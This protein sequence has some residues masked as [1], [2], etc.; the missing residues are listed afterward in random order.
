MIF[1]T[2]SRIGFCDTRKWCGYMINRILL[3]KFKGIKNWGEIIENA[4]G[5]EHI[6]EQPNEFWMDKKNVGEKKYDKSFIKQIKED[7]ERL[8][9]CCM[10]HSIGVVCYLDELYPRLLRDIPS[11]PKMIYYK[12]RLQKEEN[13]IAVVGS[14]NSSGY[15]NRIAKELSY[16]L[17][18]AGLAVVSGA[19]RGIDTFAHTGALHAMNLKGSSRTI[20]VV[21]CGLNVIYPPENKHLYKCIAEKGA[22]L[23]EYEPEAA[24]KAQ[25]FPARNRIISGMSMGTV[26]VEAGKQS[27]SLITAG[28]AAEYGRDVFAV[29]GDVTRNL[30]V[31]TNCLIKDGA[32]PVCCVKDILDVV[33]LSQLR[34][35]WASEETFA[36]SYE[37]EI[38]N[39]MNNCESDEEKIIIKAL[40]E[41]GEMQTD[42]LAKCTGMSVAEINSIAVILEFKGFVH[43]N[44]SGF[45]TLI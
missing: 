21:G 10:S 11:F 15:G 27:G 14:R 23:S 8:T 45:F 30:S 37:K 7:S 2:S 40:F 13:M 5:M 6:Y 22:V 1:L 9:E 41:G 42:Q 39:K 43:K 26:V 33:S 38:N 44:E 4:G 18:K 34:I 3:S 35:S 20:A 36:N 28:M 17:V 16:G 12:G 24:P 29:P 19:A 32:V 25:H 31:G